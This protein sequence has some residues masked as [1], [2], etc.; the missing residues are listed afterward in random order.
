[1]TGRDYFNEIR[2]TSAQTHA[3]NSYKDE[4]VCFRDD[5]KPSFTVVGRRESIIES[6]KR[7]N[8][9]E[10]VKV[11]SQLP[12]HS[13]IVTTYY[14]GVAQEPAIYLF[15]KETGDYSIEFRKPMHG[16]M[17]YA[18]NWDTGRY[19]LMVYAL[20]TSSTVPQAEGS[21]RC[22]LIHPSAQ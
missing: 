12:P 17:T 4:Y 20:D 21:G 16:R 10:G 8:D 1:M 6:M 15:D 19:R 22:E 9:T 11:L 3:L 5:N 13:I 14:K 2:A 7:A 18:I